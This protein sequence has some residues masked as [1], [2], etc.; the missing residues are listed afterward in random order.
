MAI[1]LVG[2]KA[3]MTRIFTDDGSSIPVTVIEVEPNRVTYVRT[4]EKEGYAAI[5]VTAGEARRNRVSKAEAGHFAK[6]NVPAGRGLWEF[7]V[8]G[9]QHDLAVS[10]IAGSCGVPMTTAQLL[11]AL[12]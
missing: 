5:Q 12:G 9:Q 4:P 7:R 3:G 11:A 1:G 2:R 8:D 6:A 10:W